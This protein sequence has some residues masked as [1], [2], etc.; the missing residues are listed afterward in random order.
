MTLTHALLKKFIPLNSLDEASLRFIVNHSRLLELSAGERLFERGDRLPYSYFLVQGDLSLMDG[1]GRINRLSA[2]DEQAAYG[3]GN[4]IPRQIRAEVASPQAVILK[5]D[6]QL[7]EREL[8]WLRLTGATDLITDESQRLVSD[9]NRQ[10]FLTFLRTPAFSRLPIANVEQLLERFSEVT[11]RAGEYVIREND[12][13]DY[14]YLIRRGQC[15]VTRRSGQHEVVLNHL[16]EGDG[17]GDE[18]LIAKQPRGASVMMESDGVLLRL[19]KEDFLRLLQAPSLKHVGIERARRWV[20]AGQAFILDVRTESEYA[21]QHLAE[22]RNIPLYL[23]Y[24]K[25]KTFSPQR[26]YV[27]YCDYGTRSEAAAFMLMQRGLDAYLLENA[28]AALA[29]NPVAKSLLRR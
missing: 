14:Y 22:A 20:A 15:R 24:L 26:R 3:V 12:P 1:H 6:R 9:D 21:Y 27:V 4:L 5:C 25:S 18:A 10:W 17:F 23:L 8:A 28:G 2:E 11:Y 7:L 19:S 29:K 13:A 16:R